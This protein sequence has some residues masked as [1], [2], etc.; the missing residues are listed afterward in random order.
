MLVFFPL[1]FGPGEKNHEQN[2]EWRGWKNE[3]QRSTWKL[4]GADELRQLNDDI[5]FIGK[6]NASAIKGLEISAD[7]RAQCAIT[8]L[9][10]S[11]PI[12]KH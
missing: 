1:S 7:E 10:Y 8:L 5:N 11:I 6:N 2:E 4:T 3:N 9:C 12:N